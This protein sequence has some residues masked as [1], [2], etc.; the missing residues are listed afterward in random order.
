MIFWKGFQRSVYIGQQIR[1]KTQT[2][3][4][5]HRNSLLNIGYFWV[6][7][8]KISIQFFFFIALCGILPHTW[9]RNRTDVPKFKPK[10]KRRPQGW[11]GMCVCMTDGSLL[12]LKFKNP[13][14]KPSWA[15]LTGQDLLKQ[16]LHISIQTFN[17]C[18]SCKFHAQS[19]SW[20]TTATQ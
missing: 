12:G 2:T 4:V 8:K 19:R 18:P 14:K 7:L 9:S 13:I 5:W 16:W 1:A 17:V 10:T 6:I 11:C 15:E 3:L 20:W